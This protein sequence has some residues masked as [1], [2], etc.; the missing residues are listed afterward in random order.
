[1]PA[2]QIA[3]LILSALVTSGALVFF[4]KYGTRLAFAERDSVK[5][6]AKAE[7]H[8]KEMATFQESLKGMQSAFDSIRE[9]LSRLHV[10]DSVKSS[11]DV[12]SARL[13]DQQRDTADLKAD[14]RSIIR[15]LPVNPGNT[16]L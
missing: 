11:V 6:L 5:A 16:Q 7:A 8:D 12:L 1:M 2:I 14:L 15:S 4:I 3:M 13:Q 9:S 10:L